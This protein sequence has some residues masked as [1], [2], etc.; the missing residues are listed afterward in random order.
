MFDAKLKNTAPGAVP[1]LFS[2]DTESISKLPH[3]ESTTKSI[4]GSSGVAV[5]D[6][7]MNEHIESTTNKSQSNLGAQQSKIQIY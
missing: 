7:T 3:I 4:H 2:D 6:S 1:P 5:T